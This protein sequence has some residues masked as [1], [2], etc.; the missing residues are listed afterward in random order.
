MPADS[1]HKY[2]KP[3]EGLECNASA[4]YQIHP[5]TDSYVRT[6]LRHS[7]PSGLYD[8]IVLYSYGEQNLFKNILVFL[9]PPPP[10]LFSSFF[11]LV[12]GKKK[13]QSGSLFI[14]VSLLLPDCILYT[15]SSCGQASGADD[16]DWS[17]DTFNARSTSEVPSAGKGRQGL[18]PWGVGLV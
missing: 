14:I 8:A 2:M 18:D 17:S 11:N 5:S 6:Q 16:W 13:G 3:W 1:L 9:P 15:S 7:L 12:H 4:R 10:F